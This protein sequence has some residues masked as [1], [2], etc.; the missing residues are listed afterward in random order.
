V[1]APS[2]VSLLAG[3]SAPRLRALL[4]QEPHRAADWV[5]VAALEGLAPAQL[6]YGRML[7]EGWGAERDPAAALAWFRRAAV[8]GDLD[9]VNL[10]GRCHEHGWGAPCDMPTAAEHYTRA[11]DA[12]HAWAQYNLGHLYLNGQGVERNYASAYTYYRRAAEQGHERA[13]NLLGRC[14]EQGWGSARNPAA[15]AEWYRRSAEAGYF[16]GEYNWATMLLA[17]GRVEEAAIWLERAAGH[18]TP[19]VRRAVLALLERSDAGGTLRRLALRLQG[20]SP[21]EPPCRSWQEFP[22][23]RSFPAF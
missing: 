20:A 22:C 17:A 10:I 5:R 8:Q 6:C 9:A 2:I 14:C 21:P 23:F 16:R 12:G 11:A 13:M 19:G 15:A 18:G 1:S 4:F 7:L 3:L